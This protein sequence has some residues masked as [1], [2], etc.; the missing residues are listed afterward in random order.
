MADAAV[1]HGR[2]VASTFEP[3]RWLRGPHA[4]TIVPSV[5]RPTPKL[6]LEIE[7]LELAD[8]DFVRVGWAGR[9]NKLERLAVFIH[10]LTGGFESKYLRGLAQRLIANHWRV[11]ILELRGAG[12]LPNRLPRNYHHGDTGDLRHLWQLLS[13]RHPGARIAAVGWSLGANVLLKALA[14]E[15]EHAAPDAAAA[16]SAPF[17]LA[18]CAE[19][20]RGGS[21]RIYQGRL[22]R[23]LKRMLV[24]KY[25]QMP[26]P[27][28]VDL[29]AALR[30][31]DFFA[32][33]NAYTA[34][35][36]GFADAQDYYTRC[37][38]GSFLA[39]IRRPTL[40]VNA[41]DDPFMQRASIPTAT[42]LAPQVTLELARRGGHVGFIGS[43][44]RGR[45]DY[46]LER[47]LADWLESVLPA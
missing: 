23:D 44:A 17:D 9:V 30:A 31:E 47:R 45:L 18:A 46:W 16:V 8:G 38:C 3:H 6:A 33:D 4:Q 22:L 43:D 24:R 28:G 7:T 41:A 29:A 42:T 5:L 39:G 35:L 40:I 13:V 25:A 14:E 27:T 36:H 34:P 1:A 15:G 11:A 10:G 19:K 37:A 32:F 21:A 26:A 2:I 20:L 12:P